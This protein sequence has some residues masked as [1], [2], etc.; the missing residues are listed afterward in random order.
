MAAKHSWGAVL[1]LTAVLLLPAAIAVRTCTLL[2]Q[3][4][5]NTEAIAT[6]LDCSST[7]LGKVPTIAVNSS[8]VPAAQASQFKGVKVADIASC[9]ARWSAQA[10]RPVQAVLAFCE[11]D[12]IQLQQPTIQG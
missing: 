7:G 12:V 10:G 4:Q 2:L 11:E 8:L 1:C 5:N 3:A 6:Q 9:T